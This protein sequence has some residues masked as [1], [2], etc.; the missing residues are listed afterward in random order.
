ME[1]VELHLK[2]IEEMNKLIYNY[3]FMSLTFL[4]FLNWYLYKF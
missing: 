2:S 3:F 1:H 4:D